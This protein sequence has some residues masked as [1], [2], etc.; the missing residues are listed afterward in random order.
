MKNLISLVIILFSSFNFMNAQNNN[1]GRQKTM[2]T[3]Y[4][5]V[6][7]DGVSSIQSNGNS[8]STDI[9]LQNGTIIRTDG[10]LTPLKGE[11]YMIKSGECVD[12]T[13]KV[14]SS[15]YHNQS[16][17]KNDIPVKQS[18]DNQSTK[19]NDQTTIKKSRNNIP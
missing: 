9:T 16:M 10:S 19:T 15:P 5:A 12:S 11:R 17:H 2:N 6:M 4:C 3:Q 18:N 8:L 14:I 7:K 1:S 13:G